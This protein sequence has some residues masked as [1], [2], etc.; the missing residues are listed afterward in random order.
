MKLLRCFQRA[1]SVMSDELFV[2][3]PKHCEI[4]HSGDMYK[5]NCLMASELHD[6]GRHHKMVAVGYDSVIIGE[7]R[8]VS[9]EHPD[10]R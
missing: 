5:G 10:T 7:W 4:G 1:V 2:N 8:P 3:C 6:I 9:S